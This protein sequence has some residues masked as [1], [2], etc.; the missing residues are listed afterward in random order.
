MIKKY[1]LFLLILFSVVNICFS[2]NN[3][4]IDSRDGKTYKTVQIGDQVWMASNL[5]YVTSLTYS[6]RPNKVKT[7][8]Y[9]FGDDT[10]SMQKYG[11]G[12]LYNWETAQKVC[13]V[14]W[15][16]PTESDFQKLLQTAGKDKKI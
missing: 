9:C 14:G 5:A 12:Y 3:I 7:G 6:F 8:I 1:L 16:L 15:H 11:Y 13:P 10:V 2:Q 4:L